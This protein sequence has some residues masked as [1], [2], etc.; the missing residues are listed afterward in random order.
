MRA[1]RS[2]QLVDRLVHHFVLGLRRQHER[3]ERRELEAPVLPPMLARI[4]WE[5]KGDARLG[6]S[7]ST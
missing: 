7:P 6:L 4:V 5:E 2:T 1:E 3:D